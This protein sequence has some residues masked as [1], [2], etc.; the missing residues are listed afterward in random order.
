MKNALILHGTAN[1]STRNWFPW[2]KMELEQHGYH[3]W[4]PDLPGSEKPN[5][6]RYNKFIF[7]K[8]KFDKDS[9][10]VGHSSGAVAT[11]GILQSLPKGHTIDKALLVAGFAYAGPR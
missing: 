10:I 11:L 6:K 3:V 5:L 2:L 8:W 4:A 1:D 9:V 7:S